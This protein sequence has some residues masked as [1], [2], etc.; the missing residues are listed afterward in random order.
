MTQLQDNSSVQLSNMDGD[1]FENHHH[2]ATTS[3]KPKP[4]DYAETEQLRTETQ[5]SNVRVMQASD[6][7]E[8]QEQAAPTK[9][10][11]A[12]LEAK[13]QASEQAAKQQEPAKA[14]VGKKRPRYMTS[15][16]LNDIFEKRA[17]ALGIATRRVKTSSI[18]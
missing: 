16:F 3:A 2:H 6:P 18:V 4:V 1:S 13:P 12:E 5:D 10:A 15:D 11:A 8:V 14:S 9:P 7:K 17:K